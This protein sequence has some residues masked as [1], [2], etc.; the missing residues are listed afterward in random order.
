MPDSLKNEREHFEKLWLS[1]ERSQ[2]DHTAEAWD[3]RAIEWRRSYADETNSH[4][5][6]SQ[7]RVGETTRYL[8]EKGILTPETDVMDIG[9]GPGYFV[10]DFARHARHAF[11]VDISEEMIRSGECLAEEAGLT[12]VTYEVCDFKKTSIGERGW[13]KAFDLVY[14]SITPAVCD[15][16]DIDRI[17]SMS[18]AWCLSCNYVEARDPLAD[19]AV[20]AVL[21]GRTWRG[22][23]DSRPF[24]AMF[25]L[26]WLKG[27]FPEVRYLREY[28][29]DLLPVGKT[30][31]NRTLRSQ[32]RELR[33]EEVRA[34]LVDFYEKRADS[35]GLVK[36]PSERLYGWLL[37]NVN[38]R[39]ERDYWTEHM[40][41]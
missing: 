36:Y 13:E 5:L 15:P 33:T 4:R 14:T 35:S 21:P 18:R 12:N 7:W 28:S 22:Y 32:P 3:Q 24:Y 38:D 11:G 20:R 6:R 19:E 29:E 27:R 34:A 16:E 1:R 26:L 41:P 25:N 8:L 10:N 17:E 37:W 2:S 31:I 30:L 39:G 9:C 40:Q 23:G